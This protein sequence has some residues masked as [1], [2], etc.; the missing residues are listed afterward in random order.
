MSGRTY[1][2]KIRPL[3]LANITTINAAF[4]ADKQLEL[5]SKR[6]YYNRWA[7][8]R[9]SMG[10]GAMPFASAEEEAASTS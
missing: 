9:R 10:G 7:N 2:E 4:A 8:A 5:Y 1:W 3:I 6:Y